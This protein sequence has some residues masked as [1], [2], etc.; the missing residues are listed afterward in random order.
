MGLL[1]DKD[2]EAIK[3]RL[4]PMT[5]KVKLVY[6]TQEQDCQFCSE[7]GQLLEEVSELSDK[8]EL[9]VYDFA[10]NKNMAEEYNITKIPATVMTGE[11]G[12]DKG[13]RFYGIPSGYEFAT[14]LEDMLMISAGDSGL[15]DDTKA[16]LKTLDKDVHFQVFVT[17]T[18]PYCPGAV[19]LAHQ[20]AF[21]SGKVVGDMVEATEF[22]EL[23][24]KYQVMGVPRTI[25][26]EDTALEGM[27]PEEMLLQELQSL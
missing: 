15:G 4:E 1:Q 25:I 6:F 7:T 26:N 16:F 12:E 5:G 14:L 21:E 23:S 13:I 19:R 27:R 24:Q 20:M 9:E 17:P 18:C 10:E 2:K 11:D 8:L 3:E 22:P